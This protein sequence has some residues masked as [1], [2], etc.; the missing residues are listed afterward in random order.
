MSTARTFTGEPTV[1]GL[2][3]AVTLVEG[4]SFAISAQSGDIEPGGA[5]G[6]FH[7]DTRFVSCWRLRV[8]GEPLQDLAV[9]PLDPFAATFVARGVPHEGQSESTI[10]VARSR[11]VGNGMRE[12]LVVRNLAH[13]PVEVSIAIDLDSDFAHIFEVKE[14]RVQARGEHT[15]RAEDTTL[16][17]SNAHRGVTRRL[18]VDFPPMAVVTLRR[19]TMDVT[20]PP[21]GEWRAC[22]EFRAEIDDEPIDLRY[23]CGEPVEHSEPVTRLRSW[24]QSAPRVRTGQEGLAATFD[25]S[26]LDLGAL[27][28]FDPNDETRAVVAAG[29]PWFM[30]LFGRDSLITGLMTL[31][32]DP[33]LA[34]GILL[35]LARLQGERVDPVSEEEPGKILHEIRHGIAAGGNRRSGSVYYGSIDATPLFVVVL[36]E[37]YR[38]GAS[39]ELIERLLPHADR[40]LAWVDEYGDRDGDG[41]VEY[42]RSTPAGLAN[43][44]WKD[45][46]DGVNFADGTIAEP[47]IAL[48]EVQG[49]VY[50]ALCARA[51]IARGAGDEATASRCEARAAALKVAFNERFWLEDRG[52]FAVGLDR[53]KRPIDALTSNLGHCLWTGI[54]DADKAASVA[55]HLSGPEM[56]TGWGLRT[57]G[58]SMGAYN[59]VSYHN[60]SVWPHDSAIG[61]AGLMRY[62][63][64][65]EAL[66]I[67]RGVLRVAE[68]F[69]G[70]LPELLCGF[71]DDDFELP[72]RYPTSCSPQA[73]AS[74]T[75]HWLVRTILLQLDPAIPDGVVWL[76]PRIPDDIGPLA[77][78]NVPLAGSRISIDALGTSARVHGLPS[79]LRMHAEVR[80]RST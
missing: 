6:L 30:T 35:T 14:G 43:Q 74:A 64:V 22:F 48:C 37:L 70:R 4:N 68:A 19:A 9:V 29:A 8:D 66:A 63:F 80:P 41:F 72:V 44:G 67:A 50:R 3:G 21:L 73:W 40:A 69:G 53:D 12:D 76:A 57:L 7:A 78:D 61:A 46:F 20:V 36:G 65:D 54:V 34:E 27:R 49:Y 39:P 52:H 28:I 16:T 60:G 25:Q 26:V 23:R 17:F 71:A 58:S 42:A 32:V 13:A 55:V 10:L 33:T 11:F 45:S 59:P 79:G 75:P 47:P 24:E 62:G 15:V 31:A 77:L 1:S 38:W 56:F 51:E 5:H 2:V 18:V